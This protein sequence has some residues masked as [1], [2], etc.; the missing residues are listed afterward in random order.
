MNTKYFESMLIFGHTLRT[1]IAPN[2]QIC[3]CISAVRLRMFRAI[4]DGE[5]KN[6]VEDR[7]IRTTCYTAVRRQRRWQLYSW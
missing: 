1:R 3:F 5:I 4:Q 2:F 6:I 7:V